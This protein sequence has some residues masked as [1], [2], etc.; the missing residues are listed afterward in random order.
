MQHVGVC[1]S[2]NVSKVL[3]VLSH[4]PISVT[5]LMETETIPNENTMT[6]RNDENLNTK[7]N[8][9]KQESCTYP[10]EIVVIRTQ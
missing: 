6:I 1:Q 5:V 10:A 4:Y 9:S 8:F 2:A 7:K 3:I